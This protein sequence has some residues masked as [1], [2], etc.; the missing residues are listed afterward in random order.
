[1]ILL[2]GAN[3]ADNHPI[4]CR[5]LEANPNTTLIV[6]DPRVT[7]TAMMADIHLP[8]RPRSDLALINGLIH[9]VI[10]CGAVTRNTHAT[11]HGLRGAEASPSRRTRLRGCRDHRH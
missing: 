4:L 2:I 7:K 11:H 8:I 1:V 9:L 10:E 6:V 3:I 5:R